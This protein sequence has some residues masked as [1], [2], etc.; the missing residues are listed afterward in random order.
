MTD[1]Q[2]LS[3]P[4]PWVVELDFDAKAFR[5]ID[6]EDVADSIGRGLFVWVDMGP[7]SLAEYE[8]A[9]AVCELP[10]VL[11]EDAVSNDVGTQQ[12]RYPNC[13]HMVLTGCKLTDQDFELQRVDVVVAEKYLLTVHASRVAF[14]ERVKSDFP[15]DFR[16]H[17]QT[18]SFLLYELWDHLLDRYVLVQ[19]QFEERVLQ[20]QTTLMGEADDHV[21]ADIAELS[22]DLVH[23]RKVL[24]PARAVL[25]DL[26]T[27]RSRFV[28]AATQPFL[29]NMV[30]TVER[31]LQ[32]LLADREILSDALNLHVTAVGHRTNEV[33]RRLT[34]VSVVFLP[35]TFLVG[36]YGMN[37][38]VQPE[39]HWRYGYLGF[40][41][42]T[43]VLT[44]GS[45]YFLIRKKLL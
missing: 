5:R 21:F 27:R 7:H 10:E 6:I 9:L 23:F 15:E 34:V 11:V 24:L 31:V 35:L 43:G 4:K 8:D 42:L 22:A 26:S 29:N 41:L 19:D 40:W 20:M 38:E 25:T 30:G 28:S 13:L 14:L 2:T 12:A 16:H 1:A 18:P 36:V 32:D 45:L 37:F 44:I 39:L 3:Q 17:A 33:M